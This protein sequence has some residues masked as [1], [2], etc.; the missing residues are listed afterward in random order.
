MS[1]STT[2]LHY[3][4]A[5]WDLRVAECPCDAD[6]VAWL[7]D[8]G[9]RGAAIY[10]FGTG[11]HHHVGIECARPERRNDVFGITAAPREYEAF[12]T[13]AIERPELLRHYT[14]V[15]SDIYL[16]ND[17][18]LPAFDVVTLF[19]LCEFRSERNDAYGAL[20]DLEVTRR[21]AGRVK[22]GG[23]LLFFP[24]SFAFDNARRV[25]AEWEGEGG[26]EPVGRYRSLLVYRKRG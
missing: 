3:W 20:T 4:D 12:I 15:F 26:F 2:A 24:G 6:F 17:R 18:L 8:T 19:H 5:T 7:D 11:A 23:H 21:L 25:I 10:H 16:V 9:T 14:C 1:G 13:L 22:P